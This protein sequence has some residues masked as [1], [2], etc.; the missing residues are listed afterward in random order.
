MTVHV[1]SPNIRKIWKIFIYYSVHN[2]T[3]KCLVVFPFH[4]LLHL[5]K[6]CCLTG[7]WRLKCYSRSLSGL[8]S[9]LIPIQSS[10]PMTSI[11]WLNRSKNN[12]HN[13]LKEHQQLLWFCFVFITRNMDQSMAT[14]SLSA[15]KTAENTPIWKSPYNALQ[16]QYWINVRHVCEWI[17]SLLMYS[18]FW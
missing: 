4:S 9:F 13:K 7:A 14:K 5:H 6:G 17:V 3:K 15:N 8:F 2:I 12:S 11:F 10:C 16:A 1:C 18:S